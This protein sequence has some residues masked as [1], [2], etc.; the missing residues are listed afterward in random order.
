MTE[1][2]ETYRVMI[3]GGGTGGHIFPAIS[4]GQAL[5][6]LLNDVSIL[7][8]G[9]KGKMEMQKVPEAGFE[10][11]GLDISG[12]QRSL[13]IKNLMFPIRLIKSI[14]QSLKLIKEFQP[15]VV[16]GV[17]GYASGPLLY[18]ASLKKIPT[19][20]Q[21]QNSYAGL[22]NKWLSGKANTI[23]VAYQNMEKY[24]PAQKLRI[25]GNPV[26]SD[27]LSSY[28]TRKEALQHFEL[29]P[30]FK[31]I[32]IIGGSLGA[33]SINEAV[34]VSLEYWLNLDFQIIW[35]TGGFY[36]EEMHRRTSDIQ[37]QKL[38]IL[39]FIREM[40]NAYSTAD[41]VISRSGALSLA[42]FMVLGIASILIPSPNVAEDHQTKNAQAMVDQ[43]A[44]I[45][46]PD[47]MAKEKLKVT[48]EQLLKDTNKIE[49]LRE[50]IKKMA[51][52]NAAKEIATEVIKLIA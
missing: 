46:L 35:Q 23:C 37:D 30:E 20:I 41:I 28:T 6:V 33:R 38:I 26:R 4:I 15:D 1:E 47:E 8:V 13:S 25:T 31:T 12:I 29:N 19:L 14:F 5:K 45:L 16:V 32:L 48:A 18:A 9:A 24:F 2:K 40:G 17:G 27:L 49:E 42:E 3:S 11:I 51:H 21:E 7:F 22:T 50:N 10:I 34:L 43:N 52:P 36:Y 39:P 44:A